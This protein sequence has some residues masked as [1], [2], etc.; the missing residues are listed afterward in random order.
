[1]IEAGEIGRGCGSSDNDT[2]VGRKQPHEFDRKR[3]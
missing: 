2:N 1:M 3:E